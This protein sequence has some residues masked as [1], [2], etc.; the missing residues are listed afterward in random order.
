MSPVSKGHVRAVGVGGRAHS[1]MLSLRSAALRNM[2]INEATCFFLQIGT[3][4]PHVSEKRI[5]LIES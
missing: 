5:S 3:R 2:E 1:F 4:A